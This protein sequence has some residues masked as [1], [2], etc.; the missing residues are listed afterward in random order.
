[1]GDD[2]ERRGRQEDSNQGAVTQK[3]LLPGDVLPQRAAQRQNAKAP[4][5]EGHATE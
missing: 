4:G 2:E 5:L 1:M 3:R